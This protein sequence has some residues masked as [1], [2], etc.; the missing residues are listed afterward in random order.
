MLLYDVFIPEL[1]KIG[2][3]SDNKNEVFEE[4]VDHFCQNQKRKDREHLLEILWERESKMSTGI[5]NGIAIPHGKSAAIEEVRGIIGISRKGID[6]G[7]IDGQ[8]VFVL[9][10]LFIPDEDSEMYLRLLKHLT[11]LL[12][13]PKFYPETLAQ[14]DPH[15]VKRIIKKYEDIYLASE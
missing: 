1:I 13:N 9:F 2:L 6:Y 8:P 15:G 14:N 11:K 4:L 7:A 5:Q 3:D 12:D 10:M